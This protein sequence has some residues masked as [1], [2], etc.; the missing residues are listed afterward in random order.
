MENGESTIPLIQRI[1]AVLWPSFL[2]AGLTTIIVFTLY[3]PQIVFSCVGGPEIA[4]L[5]AYTVGFFFF[6]A[7]N[8]VACVMSMYFCRPCSKVRGSVS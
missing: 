2:T 3:D 5:G 7:I 4:R 6:W 1:V 8:A